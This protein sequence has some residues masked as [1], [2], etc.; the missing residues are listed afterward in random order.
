[1]SWSFQIAKVKGIEIRVHAT[2]ALVLVWAAVDWGIGQS[3]GPAGAL[4]GVVFV[5]LLFLCVTLHELG[6]S[7][8]ALHY[9]AKVR[10][11][12]LLPIG[13]LARLEGEMARPGQELWMS[14]AGP[15]VNVVLAV[16]LGAVTVPLLG[17]RALGGL[18]LLQSRLNALGLE[19]LLVDLLAANV[20]LAL[21]NLLPAFPMDGGRVLRALLASRMDELDATRIATRVG[22]GFAALLGLVGIF[23][24]ALNLTMIAMFIF[25]GAKQEW[26]GVQLKTALRQAPASAA[27][28]RGGVILSPSDLLARAIE[29]T[30]RSNQTDFAVFDRGYLVGMLTR[31]DVAGGFQRYG[32]NVLVERVMRTDFPVAQTGDTLL[33]LQRK[34]QTGGISVISVLEEGRFLGL[35]TLES[36]RD[37][38]QLASARQWRPGRV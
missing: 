1:M 4:Y 28:V 38:L 11:I 14:V 22:Q 23:S 13:G 19:R 5:S 32:S 34:M 20:G 35:A 30:L 9:G 24:G 16:I 27:L 6:H 36:V 18:G 12:T 15:A 7:L 31:E 29:V 33:D 26:Y 37:A 21:F 2:F 10:D 25:V 8:V 3:L 17:W